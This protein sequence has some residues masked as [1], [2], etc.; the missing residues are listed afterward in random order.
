MDNVLSRFP[1]LGE[2]IFKKLN[3]E[4]LSNCHQL[5]R[6]CRLFIE[7]QKFFWIRVIKKLLDD[8]RFKKSDRDILINKVLLKFKFDSV[9][10]IGTT[11][12]E[13][14][15]INLSISRGQALLHFAAMS[16][17]IDIVKNLSNENWDNQIPNQ[18]DN[19]GRTPLHFAAKNGHYEVFKFI[20]KDQKKKMCKQNNP[21][22]HMELTP[23]HFAAQMGHV[24]I[25]KFIFRR[26]K[27]TCS[28]KTLGLT[29][30]H[31]AAKGGHLEICKLFVNA[32]KH[33]PMTREMIDRLKD[34]N[35]RSEEGDTPFHFAAKAGHLNICQ[36]IIEKVQD[37]NPKNDR[38][39]TPLHWAAENGHLEVCELIIGQFVEKI[40][41][42]INPSNLD[43]K[44]PL[45]NALLHRHDGVYQLINQALGNPKRPMPNLRRLKLVVPNKYKKANLQ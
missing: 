40:S 28:T 34:K 18:K 25:C 10:N 14:G 26:L 16:G 32:K 15:K 17:E 30:L 37:K 22:D 41:I 33:D 3:D 9:K 21:G 27:H 38:L 8:P 19:R 45:Q 31:F 39:D 13:F 42:Y 4:S 5:T 36:F 6:A 11:I 29:P 12:R 43:G 1:H 7:D 20:W 2:Q 24:E 44:T 23:L 35:P